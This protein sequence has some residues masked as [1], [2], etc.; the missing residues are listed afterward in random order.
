MDQDKIKA[1]FVESSLNN[2][3]KARVIFDTLR[4]TIDSVDNDNV[5]DVFI[6]THSINSMSVF[7]PIKKITL[8]S[9]TIEGKI[10][11]WLSDGYV[12]TIQDIDEIDSEL[13]VLKQMIISVEEYLKDD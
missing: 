10:K 3:R 13:E 9:R 4:G 5:T 1:M 12:L 11:V 2:I 6:L 8:T 7:L